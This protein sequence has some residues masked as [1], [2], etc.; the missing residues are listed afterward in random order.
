MAL[1]GAEG[2][3]GL[4]FNNS[5]SFASNTADCFDGLTVVSSAHLPMKSM[6]SSKGSNSVFHYGQKLNQLSIFFLREDSL[7]LLEVNGSKF[8]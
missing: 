8:V 4:T 2:F 6:F 1:L 7:K 3:H 5:R